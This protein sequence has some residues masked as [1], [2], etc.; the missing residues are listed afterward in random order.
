MWRGI[1]GYL[2]VALWST[3]LQML[4]YYR[5][6]YSVTQHCWWFHFWNSNKETLPF[7]SLHFPRFHISTFPAL[8]LLSKSDISSIQ[9]TGH[10]QDASHSLV[11]KWY[12]CVREANMIYF[13]LFDV[14]VLCYRRTNASWI[15]MISYTIEH[16]IDPHIRYSRKLAQQI[17]YNI[18]CETA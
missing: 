5:F 2:V 8:S 1:P 3:V 14:Y 13:I 16:S 17:W 4:Y 7:I 15:Q 6:I 18:M 10:S 12:C 9:Q 11:N